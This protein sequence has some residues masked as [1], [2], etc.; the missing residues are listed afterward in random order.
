MISA[1][2]RRGLCRRAG[3]RLTR[4]TIGV[5]PAKTNTFELAVGFLNSISAASTNVQRGT[6]RSSRD[7]SHPPGCAGYPVVAR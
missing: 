5:N 3:R 1:A 4:L 2:G 6:G 7:G